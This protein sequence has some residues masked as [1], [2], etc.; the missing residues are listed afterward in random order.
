MKKKR[1]IKIT[2]DVKTLRHFYCDC[3]FSVFLK[4][5]KWKNA[6]NPIIIYE[7]GNNKIYRKILKK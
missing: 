1:S 2:I 5:Q 7:G 3:I 4:I 6:P